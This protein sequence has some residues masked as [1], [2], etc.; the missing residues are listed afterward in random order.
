[1]E[2]CAYNSLEFNEMTVINSIKSLPGKPE[3]AARLR[4]LI[5]FARLMRPLTEHEV[6]A[7]SEAWDQM[8]L[9]ITMTL[10]GLLAEEIIWHFSFP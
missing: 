8:K 2:T 5:H 7:L 10:P 6:A 4:V 9:P 3:D 1:M